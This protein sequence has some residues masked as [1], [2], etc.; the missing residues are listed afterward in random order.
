M[1]EKVKRL[2]AEL[3]SIVQTNTKRSY[4]DVQ[5]TLTSLQKYIK[6]PMAARSGVV[7]KLDVLEALLSVKYQ[8]KNQNIFKHTKMIRQISE[9]GMKGNSGKTSCE[10]NGISDVQT[11]SVSTDAGMQKPRPSS[12]IVGGGAGNDNPDA[13]DQSTRPKTGSKKKQSEEV[14]KASGIIV[15]N[16]E[17]TYHDKRTNEMLFLEDCLI[18][19]QGMFNDDT[20]DYGEIIPAPK[21]NIMETVST[22][23]SYLVDVV[24]KI[25]R[26]KFENQHMKLIIS[27]LHKHLIDGKEKP[28]MDLKPPKDMKNDLLTLELKQN[29]EEVIQTFNEFKTEAEYAAKLLEELSRMSKHIKQETEMGLSE[30]PKHVTGVCSKDRETDHGM[31]TDNKEPHISR[32]VEQ[33]NTNFA[34]ATHVLEEH[35]AS[36]NIKGERNCMLSIFEALYKETQYLS[37]GKT[38]KDVSVLVGQKTPSIDQERTLYEMSR[39]AGEISDI[40]ME[41]KR[42]ADYAVQLLEELNKFSKDSIMQETEMTLSKPPQHVTLASSS[43]SKD[44]LINEIEN[45]SSSRHVEQLNKTFATA[46]DVL[47]KHMAVEK[48]QKENESLQSKLDGFIKEI[49]NSTEGKTQDDVSSEMDQTESSY[50]N[51][52]SNQESFIQ[53]GEISN[54]QTI[55]ESAPESA[56]KGS[57]EMNE[58][59]SGD[60]KGEAKNTV[61]EPHP[62]KTCTTDKNKTK[63]KR[64]EKQNEQTQQ[65]GNFEQLRENSDN[66]LSVLEEKT[67][68]PNE[69]YIL[70]SD[71]KTKTEQLEDMTGKQKQL[72]EQNS[73]LVKHVNSLRTRL[74]ELAGAK[75]THGNASIADLSDPNR[76]T[77]LA[78]M[79]SELYS[80]QWTD[81]FEYLSKSNTEESDETLIC[82][83]YAI[84][85]DGYCFCK[86][87]RDNQKLKL[88]DIMFLP[89]ECT[90]KNE[91]TQTDEVSEILAK[92]L[93]EAAKLSSSMAISNI[94]KAFVAK[95][96]TKK[97]YR[98][99]MKP[100]RKY[101]E[102]CVKLC[103]YMQVQTPPVFI[104]LKT[105]KGHSFVKDM[106]REYTAKGPRIAYVVWPALFLHYKGPMLV[107]GVAQVN[108]DSYQKS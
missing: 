10:N 49:N 65:S 13:A 9:V 36:E 75:L 25:R 58:H 99:I 1:D 51:D 46:T 8:E 83:L 76:P 105:A 68:S 19:L 54:L 12:V 87:I 38:C 35:I 48:L 100:C 27:G 70:R 29:A 42:E 45:T 41:W 56:V 64:R 91:V 7:K 59:F 92:H 23:C 104:D 66:T 107:K 60:S 108:F 22:L 21:T 82:C 32:H 55:C 30:P 24:G 11:G 69:I 93:S 62:K 102:E 71:I 44:D 43:S 18:R 61:S 5:K 80:N 63:A 106:Y 3:P 103:W 89:A 39:K 97:M 16:T 85:K 6:R 4:D 17:E 98:K 72:S 74:S 67:L 94:F 14:K 79:Y 26:L 96:E 2:V 84:L 31:N 40:Q 95:K 86:K 57:N 34:R 33:L 50:S 37:E 73:E 52:N 15:Q 81:A 28:Q 20:K 77:K 101:I 78:E 47:N 53:P 88:A 90:E